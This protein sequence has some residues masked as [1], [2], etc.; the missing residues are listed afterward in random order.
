L[1]LY[2]ARSFTDLLDGKIS[3]ESVLGSGSTFIVRLP[4]RRPADKAVVDGGAGAGFS[5]LD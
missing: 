2:I 1:G 3:V 4:C 5:R